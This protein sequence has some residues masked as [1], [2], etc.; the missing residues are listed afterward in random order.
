MRLLIPAAGA[1][2][3]LAILAPSAG[4]STAFTP[5]PHR[6]PPLAANAGGAA[7]PIRV[8]LLVPSSY[9]NARQL[10]DWG[11]TLPYTTW[12][13]KVEAAWNI[14]WTG[15]ASL[16]YRVSD[17]PELRHQNHS[18]GYFQ[19]YVFRTMKAKGVGKMAGFQTIYVLFVPC[20]SPFGMDSFG[21]TP[22]HPPIDPTRAAPGGGSE[23]SLFGQGDSMAVVLGS[24]S[25]SLSSQTGTASHETAEAATNTK[26]VGQWRFHTNHP[27]T[28]WL[29]APPYIRASGTIEMADMA[30]STHW[31]ESVPTG[32]TFEYQRIYSNKASRANGDPDVPPSPDPY[33]NV[34][35]EK[36]WLPFSGASH[37]DVVATGWS[38]AAL[39]AWTVTASVA[40][41]SGKKAGAADPCSL[42]KTSFTANN[43]TTVDVKVNVSHPNGPTSWCSIELDSS[44]AGSSRGDTLHRWDV[45]LMLGKP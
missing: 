4:T 27:T 32:E 13:R 45:G 43:G 23:G 15:L 20:T 2:L 21:C 1:V 40:D 29:D 34:S 22:H 9:P 12:F 30:P 37:A 28:P 38:A 6:D 41:W 18:V 25:G 10:R 36:D 31:F 24:P 17:M 5:A 8:I 7:K 35:T 3:A 33:Y 16:G 14:P 42:P 39:R 19:D 26:G 44:G 11:D